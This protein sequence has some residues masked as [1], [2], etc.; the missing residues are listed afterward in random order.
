MAKIFISYRRADSQQISGRIHDRLVSAFG[1]R[2]IFK[3]V[4]DIPPGM[5]FR[6][7]CGLRGRA[8]RRRLRGARS[9]GRRS[10]RRLSP[11]HPRPRRGVRRRR[12]AR[13]VGLAPTDA[14]HAGHP[15]RHRTA[16]GGSEGAQ[17][18]ATTVAISPDGG[19][20]VFRDPPAGAGQLYLKRRDDLE[21]QPLAG[22]EGGTGPF[23]S[24]D[25]AWI[26]VFERQEMRKVPISGGTS[27]KL[28]DSINIDYPGGAWLDDG[29]IAF[30]AWPDLRL[31]PPDGSASRIVAPADGFDGQLPWLP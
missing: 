30:H 4:D 15:F 3:D 23:F 17:S 20:I 7:R 8:G 18:F 6:E 21:A 27:L 5:D 29:S 9:G 12:H 10:S 13:R 2:N 24:P 1:K 22:T 19:S 14:E 26:G 25:G 16:L 11:P 28:V 31:L